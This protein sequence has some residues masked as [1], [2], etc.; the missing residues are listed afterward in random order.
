VVNLLEYAAASN[1]LRPGGAGPSL[2][3]Q[4]GGY[5]TL[6]YRQA[7][8]ATDLHYVPQCSNLALGD[9]QP[10]THELSRIDPTPG[11][12]DHWLVTV[13]D[14]V[15]MAGN[16]RRFMRLLVFSGKDLS[17]HEVWRTRH[18]GS[19]SP[20]GPAADNADPD[21]DGVTNLLE[22]AFGLNP[23]QNSAHLAPAWRR[24]GNNL[25]ISFAQPAG[26]TGIIYGAEWSAT[27]APGT[28]QPLADTGSAPRHTFT[29]PMSGGGS[30]F[31]RL[32]VTT[33]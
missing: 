17:P 6:T 31:V 26:V 32:T 13:R 15:P 10:A 20:T 28:W 29:L 9:W 30:K 19:A 3:G 22:F 16:P 8:A 23:L 4:A 21:K 7:K 12:G 27:M 2:P 1:P 25:T 24:H 18:F 5:L 11:G 33:P 14:N